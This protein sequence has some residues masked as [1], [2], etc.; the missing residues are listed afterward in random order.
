MDMYVSRLLL[1]RHGH[2]CLLSEVVRGVHGFLSTL[3]TCK[4]QLG[5]HRYDKIAPAKEQ[6]RRGR[7]R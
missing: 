2:R 5:R 3:S 6:E 7:R 4:Q 1:V